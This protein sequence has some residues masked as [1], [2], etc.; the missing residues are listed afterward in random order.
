MCSDTLQSEV[1]ALQRTSWKTAFRETGVKLNDTQRDSK[2]Q[3]SPAT[4]AWRYKSKTALAPSL[5]HIEQVVD[6][7]GS[8]FAERAQQTSAICEPTRTRN[9]IAGGIRSSGNS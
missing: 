7:C 4:M 3:G 1:N 8:R 5:L 6:V 9:T 2:I